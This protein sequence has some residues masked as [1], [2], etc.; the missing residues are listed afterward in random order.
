MYICRY[1]NM[2]ICTQR[3]RERERERGSLS[4]DRYVCV[5]LTCT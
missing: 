4:L 3:E 5:Y 2:Y 1:K